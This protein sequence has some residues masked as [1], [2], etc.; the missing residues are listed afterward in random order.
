[1]SD[2]PR[3]GTTRSGLH[4]IQSEARVH[5]SRSL[6]A[7]RPAQ[8]A[9]SGT[10][11][12][13]SGRVI[14]PFCRKLYPFSQAF[15]D[16]QLR[17]SGC[18]GVFSIAADRRTFRIAPP[19]APAGE[20]VGTA[21]RV[22]RAALDQASDDLRSLAQQALQAISEKERGHP[23]PGSGSVPDVQ[24]LAARLAKRSAAPPVLSGAGER[25]QRARI[26]GLA[27]G[28]GLVLALV[29]IALVAGHGD[30]RQ[31]ALLA[32]QEAPGI[33]ADA[34]ERILAMRRRSWSPGNVEPIVGL[35]SGTIHAAA[36]FPLGEVLAPLRGMVP[37]LRGRI[38]VAADRLGEAGTFLPLPPPEQ[39][40]ATIETLVARGIPAAGWREM[41]ER[42]DRG[43]GDGIAGLG[44]LLLSPQEL[45][46]TWA[47]PVAL[48]ARGSPPDAVDIAEFEGDGR[49]LLR[50]GGSREVRYRGRLARFHGS[51]WPD[52]W[53]VLEL[54]AVSQAGGSP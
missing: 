9:R 30:A 52:A 37:L 35:E 48:I 32:H 42:I 6:D 51:G 54:R 14:C 8:S 46:G 11:P 16:R 38:W 17:C 13:A 4:R 27:I 3:S 29:A 20:E 21:T 34:G 10:M 19:P 26:Q 45:R 2:R 22:A 43:A 41:Q 31:T 18:R 1:M 47:D 12:D 25:R 15:L 28:G 7:Y 44:T 39:D 36:R 40:P 5:S 23:R 49:I 33:G 50:E 24:T 53:A